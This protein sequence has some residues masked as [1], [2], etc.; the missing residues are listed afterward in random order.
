VLEN[1]DI[2]KIV[3]K[4]R[5]NSC[6]SHP[7]PYLIQSTILSMYRREGKCDRIQYILSSYLVSKAMITI[8]L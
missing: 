2:S 7:T 6:R 3:H 5:D 8:I 1:N 4:H